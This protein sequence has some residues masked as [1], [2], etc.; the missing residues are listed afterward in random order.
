MEIQS[1]YL[2][3]VFD[4]ERRGYYLERA[5]ANLK[6]SNVEFRTIVVRGVSGLVFGSMLA[7][8]MGKGLTVVRKPNDSSHSPH[9]VEGLL[10]ESPY[11]KWLIVDDFI[12][13]GATIYSIV[14]AMDFRPGWIGIYLFSQDKLH[15]LPDG[16]CDEI[17][18]VYLDYLERNPLW[19]EWGQYAV[20]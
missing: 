13:T 10:P 12:S 19:E 17:E 18:P 11:D 4:L 2:N 8:T 15:I 9:L 16:Y 7:H 5:V 3:K 20:S 14:K 1:D 6:N